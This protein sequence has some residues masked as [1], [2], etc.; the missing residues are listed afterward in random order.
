MWNKTEHF[1][2]QDRQHLRRK[3]WLLFYDV[4][5]VLILIRRARILWLLAARVFACTN[6]RRGSIV[7]TY[8]QG[9]LVLVVPLLHL[10]S[11]GCEC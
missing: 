2:K 1:R 8:G 10:Q 7:L 9:A 6:M 3:K 11:F 5:L 4:L